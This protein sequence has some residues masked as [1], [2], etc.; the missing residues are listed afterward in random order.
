MAD[1]FGATLKVVGNRVVTDPESEDIVRGRLRFPNDHPMAGKLFAKLLGSPYAHA[2]ITNIDTSAAE[3]LPGVKAVITYKDNT[4]WSS[5]ILFWGQEVAAVAAVDEYTAE[6]ATD[7]I[8]VTYEQLPFVIYPEE[9]MQAGAPIAGAYPTKNL[10]DAPSRQ[11]RGDV[12]QGFK[13]AEI[14]V[15]SNSGWARTISMNTIEGCSGMAWWVGDHVYGYDQNQA[16]TSN[17]NSNAALLKVAQSKCHFIA[18]TGGGG[19]G[20]GGQSHEPVTCAL[21]AKKAGAPVTIQRMRR[22]QSPPRRN[23]TGPKLNMKLGFKKDGTMTAWQFS[24]WCWGG[25]NAGSGGSNAWENLDSTFKCANLLAEEWGVN[26][27][28]GLGENYRCLLHPES[29]QMQDWAFLKAAKVLNMNPLT[30]MRKCYITEDPNEPNQDPGTTPVAMSSQGMRKA[31]EKAATVIGYEAKY[32]EPGAGTPRTDGRKHGIG[33]HAHNDRHGTTSTGRGLNI[34]MNADG[35]CHFNTGQSRVQD[36]ASYLSA[37]IAETLGLKWDAVNCGVWGDPSVAS[38]GGSQAGSA[39]ATSNGGA[40]QEAAIDVKNQLFTQAVTMAPFS[41]L[42]PKP[43]IADLDASDG[44]IFLKS[45]PTKITTHAA[46]MAKIAKP[47]MGSGKSRANIIRRPQGNWPIGTTAVHR[48]GVAAAYEVA[49]DTETGE[50]EILNWVH[51]C[52]A[53]RVINAS[54]CDGQIASAQSHQIGKAF[55]WELKHDPQTGV[56]LTQNLLD[57]KLATQMDCNPTMNSYGTTG[58]NAIFLETVN[59]S[60]PFG[61]NGIGEPCAPSCYCALTNAIN[62]ALGTEIY[63]RPITPYRILKALGKI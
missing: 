7:L 62:N 61:M 12:T 31:M 57:D 30:L 55:L 43:T 36:A 40:A 26:T 59:S 44:N 52:D 5:T 34:N 32:H 14:T 20:G 24:E 10:P 9:A 16:T 53:G 29:A 46:V 58:T 11:T 27:N 15:E 63:E 8:K 35:T 6:R 19:F 3:A 22:Y 4:F 56:L 45:D 23:Q 1:E 2:K 38:D 39:G 54:V 13:D 18:R 37:I 42:T 50:V 48:T 33:I 17:R 47:I 49:V 25:Y 21:L 51:V 28:T 41:T 60:G